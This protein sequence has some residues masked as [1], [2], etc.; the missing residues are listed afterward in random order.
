MDH[1]AN[2]VPLPGAVAFQVD[3]V[4][5]AYGRGVADPERSD[6]GAMDRA[7]QHNPDDDAQEEDAVATAVQFVTGS[8]AD[9]NKP[10][11]RRTRKPSNPVDLEPTSALVSP[12]VPDD[13]GGEEGGPVSHELNKLYRVQLRGLQAQ[14]IAKDAEIKR[15]GEELRLLERERN[16]ALRKAD[17]LSAQMETMAW[18]RSM[19]GGMGVPLVGAPAD[20]SFGATEP[21]LV[22]QPSPNQA[23]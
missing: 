12:D 10:K 1:D 17:R 20:E 6:W 7:E 5:L 9:A 8:S 15:I 16:D 21:D 18:M 2:H 11:K 22:Q 19:L 14:V 4:L 23:Q 3:P 13:E